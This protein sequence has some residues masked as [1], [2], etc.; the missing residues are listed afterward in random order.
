MSDFNKKRMRKIKKDV[1]RHGNKKLRLNIKNNLLN[2]PEDAHLIIPDYDGKSSEPFN[3]MD[4]DS[5]RKKNR[6]K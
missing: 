5:T 2:N 6:K 3:G 1:K 4:D